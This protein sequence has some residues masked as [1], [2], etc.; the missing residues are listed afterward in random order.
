MAGDRVYARRFRH[1][2]T[3]TQDEAGCGGYVLG[4]PR[5]AATHPAPSNSPCLR[6]FTAGCPTCLAFRLKACPIKRESARIGSDLEPSATA[7]LVG[8]L[9]FFAVS[10]LSAVC[11]EQQRARSVLMS[12][13]PTQVQRA[14]FPH[15]PFSCTAACHAYAPTAKAAGGAWLSRCAMHN[16]DRA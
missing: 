6:L 7:S 2:P 13:L 3:H 5:F 16:R 11:A 15:Y 10:D 9:S 8:F 1:F 12:L 4:S 14:V